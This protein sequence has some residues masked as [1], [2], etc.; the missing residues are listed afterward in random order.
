MKELECSFPSD[1]ETALWDWFPP[2]RSG[3]GLWDV[4]IV[5]TTREENVRPT[6]QWQELNLPDGRSFWVAED[7]ITVAFW[8]PDLGYELDLRRRQARVRISGPEAEQNFHRALYF[9]ELLAQGGLLLHAAGVVRQGTACIFP[10]VSGAGKSTIVRLAANMPI[11][12]DELCAVHWAEHAPVCA[13]GTPFFGDWNRPGERLVTQLK[14]LYF[15]VKD[16]KN[17]LTPLSPH[18]TVTRLLPC[19]CS[20]TEWRPRLEKLLNAA[21]QLAHKVPGYVLNFRPDA[22]FW[23]VIDAS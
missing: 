21:V 23:E 12:N 2:A 15:P 17:C 6:N 9:F 22:S 20:Y 11:L 4:K 19:V 7:E 13:F 14:G 3:A 18:E 8:Y 5:Q 16:L 1:S 10:G